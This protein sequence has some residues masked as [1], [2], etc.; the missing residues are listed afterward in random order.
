[1][2]FFSNLM[3]GGG[4]AAA[5]GAVAGPGPGVTIHPLVDHGIRPG[6]EGHAGG[7]L[8]CHCSS[9]PVE[10]RVGDQ[11]AHNHICGCTKCWKPEGADFSL[12]AVVGRDRVAVAAHPDKLHVV[13]PDAAIQRHACRVCGVHMLGRIEDEGHPFHGLDF[14][15]VELSGETGWQAPQFAA[16]VSS[17]IE[18]GVPPER[19]D[20]I[21]ARLR[22][23][24]LEPYD[25]LSP[26]LMDAIATHAAKAKGT[27]ATA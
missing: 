27:P 15:H 5:P 23:L 18:G 21:R 26:P 8:R 4:T 9:D 11:V 7:I 22:Q 24:G 12:I 19:M 13:D 2:G 1:M 20:T 16:F 10:V 6:A 3:G 25:C 14:V 17:A